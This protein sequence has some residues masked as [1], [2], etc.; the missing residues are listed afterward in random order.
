[1]QHLWQDLKYGVRGI[2][3]RPG[4]A[5]L[6][7][8]TLALGIGAATT[9][10]SVIK[11]V[12]LD[13]FPYIDARRVASIQ[14]RD[15]SRSQ[16][17]GRTAFQVPEFLEYQS[18]NSVFEEVIA[19]TTEDVLMTT[20]ESTEFLQG[21]LV[22][23]NMFRF[24]GVPP[25]I[26]RG[27]TEEDGTPGTPA[28]FVMAHKMWLRQYNLD[29][30]ILGKTFILNGVPTTLVGIM[31]KRFT[32]LAAD[33]WRPVHLSLADPA[34]KDRY[35]LF[36][37]KLKPD[38]TLEQAAADVD[39][40]AKR[41]AT[42]YPKNY[43]KQFSVNVISWVDSIVGPFSKTLYTMAGAVGLLLLIACSNVANMLLAKAAAR[44]KEMAIRTS[45][46]ASRSRLV[47]Q[48]LI[49]SLLLAV[50]GAIL[51]VLFAYTGLKG[52]VLLIP[53]GYI[54]RE[55]DIRLNVPVL[56]FSLG[57]AMLT[58]LIFGLV[59]ALQ[60]VRRNMVEPLKDSGKGVSGGFRG[61]RLRSAIVI[62][63]VALSLVLLIGAGLLM[64]TFVKLQAVD[65]G[66][67]PDNLLL[68]RTPLPRGQYKD[69]ASKQRFFDELL[70]R[71]HGSPGVVAATTISALPPY[72]GI[73]TEIDI[74]GKT[75][76]ERWDAIFQLCSD[77]YFKTL[78][79]RPLRGRMLSP[80]DV[81]GA[82]RVAVINQTLASKY[83]GPE[84][85]IGRSITLKMLETFRE[86]PV[87]NPV[88]EIIGVVADAK[89]R[90]I[91]EPPGP[92]VFIPYTM[93]GGF[94]RGILVRTSGDPAAMLQTVR[95]EIWAVDRGVAITLTGTL[96][97]YLTRFSYAEPRFSLVLL[98]VFSGVGLLLVA[99]GVYSVIAY[100]VS[101]QTHEIGIRIALGAARS[102]VLR[103]VGSLALRLLGVG[104]VLG[105]LASIAATRLIASQLWTVSPYD[106]LT[107]TLVVGAMVA[108]GL[109]ACYF[110]ARRA[111]RVDPIVA[112]RYE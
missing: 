13:P 62:T 112:L 70:R 45:L 10:F 91:Q 73:G 11:N 54:P 21:G 108:I 80:A 61:G 76:T 107:L 1:M 16:P 32:K 46:G 84:D 78:G 66:I 27:L 52:L 6:A 22:S 19:G 28:V 59:P 99:I 49:E 42:I 93:T 14:I 110:P 105:L 74:S 60:T 96:N 82:R 35:F 67:N 86:G 85:P 92:E 20:G 3:Q 111:M 2:G 109:V 97:E 48:L 18:Q 8:L 44:E 24:L 58:A 12:L 33:V 98:S 31:P 38:V 71:L 72:G 68:A 53:E 90:G 51:G 63:E 9:I 29:P 106:P 95:R 25:V 34:I 39:V 15:L 104:I 5:I 75:H 79:I 37:A 65:L 64:R 55:A 7:M 69:A 30:E 4:F 43:P 56:I 100:T 36:Q 26:G 88:F 83:F 57:A 103:M 94:E 47:G 81:T 40:I 77:G 87:E 23:A 41:L 17:G 89:N 101:R 102:H 50:G